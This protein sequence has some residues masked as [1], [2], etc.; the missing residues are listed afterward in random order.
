M[1]IT[2][3]FLIIFTFTFTSCKDNKKA[4][5]TTPE[6]AHTPVVYVSNYPLYYFADR[7]GG[8]VIHL[9]FPASNMTEPANW[10][11]KT[12]TIAAMQQADFVFINGATYEK[13]LMNVS[14]PEDL[15]VNTGASF[16]DKLL[17]N[18]EI[19]THTHGD[20]EAHSHTETAYT[21]W[22]NLQYANAQ[23]EAIKIA[24]SEKFPALASQFNT[25][26]KSLSIDLLQ[27][28]QE[29]KS[30]GEQMHDAVLF[31]HPVY[32]YFMGAYGIHGQSL[33]WEPTDTLD[34]DKLQDLEHLIEKQAV[35]TLIWEASPQAE[36]IKTLQEMGITSVVIAPLSGTPDTGNFLSI[37]RANV[38]T[39]K[40]IP[41]P[42]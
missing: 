4:T 25:N 8:D 18:G 17:G 2:P 13:W 26:F 14:L 42:Q 29:F 7:I 24:L 1:R 20:E 39:L 11:P 40:H 33:H 27:L 19:F 16:E 37:M 5:A 31:S 6:E 22:L 28:D 32:Q 34:H 12:D 30:V 3:I 38:N 41:L 35:K 21:T 23:A 15:I 36:S 10:K 9:H